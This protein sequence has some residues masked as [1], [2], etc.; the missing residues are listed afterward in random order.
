MSTNG[1]KTDRFARVVT[2][3]LYSAV[4]WV[5]L[6]I[7]SRAVPL[8]VLLS[9]HGYEIGS[10]C[11]SYYCACIFCSHMGIWILIGAVPLREF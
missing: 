4:I 3:P 10:L 6:W 9:S 8:T 11:V 2:M 5:C 1:N 7:N